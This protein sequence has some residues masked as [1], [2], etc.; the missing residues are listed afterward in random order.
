MGSSLFVSLLMRSLP[1]PRSSY[2][3]AVYRAIRALRETATTGTSAGVVF[4]CPCP[5]VSLWYR[6]PWTNRTTRRGHKQAFAARQLGT[7]ATA[8]T[9]SVQAMGTTAWVVARL[10]PRA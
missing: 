10:R 8:A 4:A 1:P 3:R 5:R 9:G 6:L 2:R 7:L